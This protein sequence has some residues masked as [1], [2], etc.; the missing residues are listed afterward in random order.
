[1]AAL[2]GIE[3]LMIAAKTDA[4]T[5]HHKVQATLNLRSHL[6]LRTSATQSSAYHLHQRVLSTFGEVGPWA[7]RFE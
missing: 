7:P 3:L 2:N 6:L 5:V 4:I 1:M